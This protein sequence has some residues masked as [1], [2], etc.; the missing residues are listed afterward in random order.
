MILKPKN[1]AAD[2]V[3]RFRDTKNVM[4]LKLTF[5]KLRF[6]NRFRSTKNVMILKR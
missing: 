3:Y 4:I 2:S 5:T 1:Q 6:K